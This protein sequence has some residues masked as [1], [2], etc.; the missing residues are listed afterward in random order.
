MED[1][2]KSEVTYTVASYDAQYNEVESPGSDLR[3]TKSAATNPTNHLSQ[4]SHE[5]QLSRSHQKIQRANSNPIDPCGPDVGVEFAEESPDEA[6]DA[7]D[8]DDDDE[9][10][11]DHNDEEEDDE[12]TKSRS[13][14]D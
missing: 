14:L 12:V 7:D 3:L 6:D 10:K 4:I 13:R 5:T 11:E 1:D 9:D 2:E 8:K